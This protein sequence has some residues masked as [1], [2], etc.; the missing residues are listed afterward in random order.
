MADARNT[1]HV[2]E[3]FDRSS[4]LTIERSMS[5]RWNPGV[6]GWFLASSGP[7]PNCDAAQTLFGSTVLPSPLPA[8]ATTGEVLYAAQALQAAALPHTLTWPRLHQWLCTPATGFHPESAPRAKEQEKQKPDKKAAVNVTGNWTM[9]LEMSMGTANPSLVLKQDGEKLTGTYTGRYGT[10]DLLGSVKERAIQFTFNMTAEGQ[11]VAMA[12]AGEVAED[13]QTMKGT[14]Q[15]DEMGD[16][17]W[18]A[19]KEKEAK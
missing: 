1:I 16:A 10:F 9:T 14:A 18:S 7:C 2:V 13:G 3:R 12:F 19:K 11:T 5:H 8:A 6:L 15:L 4:I 17:T